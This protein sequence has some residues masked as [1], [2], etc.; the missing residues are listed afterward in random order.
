MD[1]L[2]Q[3]M[4]LAEDIDWLETPNDSIF[5]RVFDWDDCVTAEDSFY[6]KIENEKIDIRE[7]CLEALKA[8]YKLLSQGSNARLYVQAEKYEWNY[9]R[10][11]Y[12]TGDFY[13]E[14]CMF[15]ARDD[16]FD[17]V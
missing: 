4:L 1:R 5:L 13:G 11:L 12:P 8:Y 10:E 16:L 2:E 7:A 15:S 3:L 17:N 9:E 14:E 6:L